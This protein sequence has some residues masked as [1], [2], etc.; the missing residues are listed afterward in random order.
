MG[1]RLILFVSGNAP[2]S[3]RARAN[4]AEAVRAAGS[5][6]AWVYEV[7]VFDTPEIAARYDL[8]T[9]PALVLEGC[10]ITGGW[11]ILYGD[12]SDTTHVDRM[13]QAWLAPRSA[14]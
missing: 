5:H 14:P 4:L 11:R 1:R 2:R 8:N 10:D 9:A 3:A 13:V 12:L 7:C 6:I